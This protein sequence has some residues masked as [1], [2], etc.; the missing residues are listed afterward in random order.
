MSDSTQ[1]TFDLIL[2]DCDV[3]AQHHCWIM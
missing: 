3:S 2:L 1:A